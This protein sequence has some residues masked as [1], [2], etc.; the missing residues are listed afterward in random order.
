MR[1]TTAWR[2]PTSIARVAFA[3]AAANASRA[4]AGPPGHR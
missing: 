4:L 3:A 2:V 1:N